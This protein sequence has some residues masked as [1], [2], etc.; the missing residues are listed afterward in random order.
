PPKCFTK[1]SR[2]KFPGSLNSRR[3]VFVREGLDDF[4]KS[5]PPGQSLI[6]QASLPQIHH[7]APQPGPRK[8]QNEL[9]KGAALLSKLSSTQQARKAFLE[10]VEAA[11]ARHP[12]ALY[13]HLEEALPAEL[14]LQVLEVLDPE[15]KLEDTWAYCQ[16]TREIMKEPTKLS[17]KCPQLSPPK[18]MPESHSGQWLYKEKPSEVDL[19]CKDSLLHENVRRGVCDF[20]HWATA[21]GSSKIDEEFILQQ[22]DIDYQ[23]RHSCDVLRVMRLNQVPWELKKSNP[24]KP[25]RVKMRY[26]AWYLNTNLWK[27]QRV[28]E[29]LMDPKLSHRAQDEDFKQQLQEQDELLAELHGTVAF[30]NFVLSRGYRMPKF[31]EKMY[32][33]K[34]G[35]SWYSKTPQNP[36]QA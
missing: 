24:Y 16:D 15:R 22:F 12:L 36:T 20:C 28:D 27:S 31:F 26:G 33:K 9:P 4:R 34:K 35:K 1:H 6:T 8:S 23:T 25:K 29:P 17:E 3:W 11:L 30:K 2:L 21:S 13:P 10:D 32:A 14:L 7:R 18:K 19:L 5:C